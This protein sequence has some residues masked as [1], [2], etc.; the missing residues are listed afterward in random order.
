MDTV[1]VLEMVF[2]GDFLRKLNF[3]KG[4]ETIRYK[5]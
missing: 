5:I 3:G 2:I 1:K 4:Y